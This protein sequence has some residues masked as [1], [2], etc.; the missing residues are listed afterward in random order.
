MSLQYDKL[1]NNNEVDNIVPSKKTN[2][3]NDLTKNDISHHDKPDNHNKV[4]H[5]VVTRNTTLCVEKQVYNSNMKLI[6]ALDSLT[7]KSNIKILLTLNHH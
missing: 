5:N 1:D 3:V 6:N 7:L 2:D 4:D